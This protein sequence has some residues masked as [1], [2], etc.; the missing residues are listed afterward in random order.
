MR[1][2][3]HRN[4]SPYNSSIIGGLFLVDHTYDFIDRSHAG[5]AQ[6]V[7][8]FSPNAVIE[9]RFQTPIRTQ[10][11]NRFEATGSGPSIVIPGVANF[12]NS[13]DVGFRY[14][15]LSP[16][17]T[18]NFSHNRGQH[19]LKVGGSIRLIRDTQV[20][21]TAANY[22]FPNVAAYLAARDG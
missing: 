21:A 14:E 4:N 13:I 22:T 5:A 15:E 18:E 7:S 1:Y 2:S 11:Q 9:L 19:A 12:G 16:E 3:G 8:V 10:S 17:V 6:L 20:Q